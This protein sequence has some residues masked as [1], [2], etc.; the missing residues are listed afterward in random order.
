M[1]YEA[2]NALIAVAIQSHAEVTAGSHKIRVQLN[3]T[4]TGP[5]AA[6]SN[7]TLQ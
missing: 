5:L 1:L 6:M 2:G 4:T 7:L 3:S